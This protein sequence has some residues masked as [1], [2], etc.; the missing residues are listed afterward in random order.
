M[1]VACTL[2]Q[3]W[4]KKNSMTPE[5]IT[6]F[7]S[8]YIRCLRE[9][10]RQETTGTKYG[11][12]HLIFQLTQ[13][14]EMIPLRLAFLRGKNGVPKPKK[15]S[16]F[17][18][19]LKVISPDGKLLCIYVLKAL[20]LTYREWTDNFDKDMTLA[21]SQDLRNP[22]LSKV[23]EVKIILVYNKDDK[24]DGIKAYDNFVA[25]SSTK[26]GDHARLSFERWDLSILTEKVRGK[27]L[28]SPSFLPEKF[29]QKFS[30]ICWQFGDFRHGSSHWTEVLIPAWREFLEELLDHGEN[31]RTLKLVPL[32][33]VILQAHQ[34]EDEPSAETSWIELVEI[35]VLKV[36]DVVAKTGEEPEFLSI[37][38]SLW[39]NVYLAG[40]A[41][42]Y[43]EHA[44]ALLTEDSL[45]HSGTTAF[46]QLIS[47]HHCYW[48]L[49]RLGIMTNELLS[50]RPFCDEEQVEE[51]DLK[52]GDYSNL[53]FGLVMKNSGCF[54]P[55]LDIHHIQIFLVCFGLLRMGR[56][57]EIINFVA[58]LHRRLLFRRMGHGEF[59][60]IDQSNYWPSAMNYIANKETA[61]ESFGRSTY[62]L[63]ML[64]EI[65]VGLGTA[66]GDALAIEIYTNLIEGVTMSGEKL[67]FEVKVELQ[68]WAPPG[69]WLNKVLK[70]T[71][72]NE[73]AC[74]TVNSLFEISEKDYSEL[75][76][77][78]REFISSLRVQYSEIE[79]IGVPYSLPI[80]AS[81]A[82]SSPLPPDYWRTALFPAQ[83]A[84]DGM[85]S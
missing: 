52:I 32:A 41:R 44:E 17:G 85:A 16:E 48:H 57:N 9:E 37:A 80:L 51:M 47:S 69:D 1:K 29:F 61:P 38:R 14:E 8:S 10:T 62:L 76:S 27:L 25:A 33:L 28:S 74:I 46:S 12:D 3:F 6:N 60:L 49:A 23:E 19:D 30:Y 53:L 56:K 71:V 65:C 31:E 84:N 78:I 2:P 70:G 20:S 59:P 35:A 67:N 18:E 11:F 43:E 54:R 75:P 40:L 63:Q 36:W 77:R 26:V 45:S 15:E 68:S 73:G 83:T 39:T 24:A 79:V 58:E 22:G 7:L 55:T 42:F 34:K 50:L 81:V 64:L 13:A 21:R 4:K 5:S 66:E 82:H 72:G